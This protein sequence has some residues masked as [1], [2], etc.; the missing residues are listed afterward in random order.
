M[1]RDRDDDD[2]RDD[3][4]DRPRRRSSGG[5]DELSGL[6]KFFKSIAVGI[7]FFLIGVFCCPLVS[8]ILGGIG[9]ATCKNPD[10]KRN[11]LIALVGG[12]LGLVLNGVLF[13]T[14]NAPM[15]R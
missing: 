4:D 9:A 15:N 8:L 2:M 6:D 3:E 12:V 7:I 1:A 14:G 10:S 5:S 11:A 13:A